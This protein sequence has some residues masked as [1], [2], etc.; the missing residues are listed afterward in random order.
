MIFLVIAIQGNH[1]LGQQVNDVF[2]LFF[3]LG[4]I[5][6][7]PI[8]KSLNPFAMFAKSRC[9]FFKFRGARKFGFKINELLFERIAFELFDV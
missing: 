1:G 2:E 3:A 6:L 8:D 9:R 4:Q 5:L 7:L